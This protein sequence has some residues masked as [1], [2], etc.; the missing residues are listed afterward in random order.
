MRACTVG[1]CLCGVHKRRERARNLGM[2]TKIA[3]THT[4]DRPI[5]CDFRCDFTEDD[6]PS[7]TCEEDSR[8]REDGSV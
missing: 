4:I 8:R 7:C 2:D 3:L 6:G 1:A 5:L